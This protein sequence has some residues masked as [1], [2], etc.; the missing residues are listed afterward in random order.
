MTPPPDKTMG[1]QIQEIADAWSVR[2]PEHLDVTLRL[3]ALVHCAET[4]ARKKALGETL[5]IANKKRGCA[6][7]GC[8]YKFAIADDIEALGEK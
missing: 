4:A 5:A 1:A 2:Q 6:D 8:G 3:G 7:Y